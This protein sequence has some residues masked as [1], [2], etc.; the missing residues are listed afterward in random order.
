MMAIGMRHIVLAMSDEF[1]KQGRLVDAS[2][3]GRYRSPLDPQ[4]KS[5]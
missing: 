1:R 5:G 3:F 4:P 2:S